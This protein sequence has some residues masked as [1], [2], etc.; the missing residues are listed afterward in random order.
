MPIL[1]EAHRKNIP[2]IHLGNGIYQLGWGSKAKRI[3]RSSTELDSPIGSI[4]SH[5]KIITASLLR[6]ACLPA[7]EHKVAQS[8]EEALLAATTMGWPLVVKPSDSDRGEGV[9]IDVIDE[10]MLKEAFSAAKKNS[11]SKRIL[12]EKQVHGVCCRIFIAN[13]KMLYAVKRLPKSVI[14]NGKD[15]IKQLIDEANA[16][17]KRLP[18]WKRSEPFPMDE[19][20]LEA[21]ELSGFTLDSIPKVNEL[22]PLRK[23]ESTQWGGFDEDITDQLI[24]SQVLSHA[25]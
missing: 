1:R 25:G 19:Q 16:R 21:M 24:N 4:M 15:T 13:Q 7:A 17:E 10:M 8:Q 12:V 18:P 14:G 9:T 2:F 20:A 5:N 3:N 23:I 6:T 11:R 22:V